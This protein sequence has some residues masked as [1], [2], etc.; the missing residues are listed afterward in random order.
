MRGDGRACSKGQDP[1]ERAIWFEPYLVREQR[2]N[3][4]QERLD[5]HQSP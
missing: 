5:Y 2:A 4:R 1:E 3:T